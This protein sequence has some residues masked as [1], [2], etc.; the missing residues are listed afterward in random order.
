MPRHRIFGN[1]VLTFLTKVASG[2]WH[3][4]DPQNGYTAVRTDVLRRLP[5]D[6]IA[7]RYEFENDLLIWLN[8]L[9]VRALDVPDTSRLPRRGVEHP[10][11]QSR[12][13]AA[14]A[15]LLRLLAAGVAQVRAVVVLADRTAAVHRFG[16]GAV[17]GCWSGLW[18][19]AHTLGPQTAS[20]GTVLL[21]VTPFL[22]G[23][24]DA[25]PGTRARHP[26]HAGLI[27]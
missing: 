12:L 3:L 15:A 20:A 1:V 18:V 21:A 22:V 19:L 11:G 5:L 10:A 16:A 27:N 8:I 9:D 2:Y 24:A 17:R 6:K 4:V 13:S 26:G 7:K 14:A 23:H 25:H